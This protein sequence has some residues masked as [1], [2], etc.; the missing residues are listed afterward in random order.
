MYEEKKEVCREPGDDVD[1]W[2]IFPQKLGPP[3]GLETFQILLLYLKLFL[4]F[5]L[6]NIPPPFA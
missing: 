1:A 2:N 6:L 5:S 3:C 4:I